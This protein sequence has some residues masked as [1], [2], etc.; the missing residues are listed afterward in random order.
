MNPVLSTILDKLAFVAIVGGLASLP[1]IVL[2]GWRGWLGMA[3]LIPACAVIA[4]I[5]TVL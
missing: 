2:V 1:M 5:A 4:G 3:C